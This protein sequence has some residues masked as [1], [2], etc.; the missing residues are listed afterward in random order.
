ME[1]KVE[2]GEYRL[3]KN[4]FLTDEDLS[5]SGWYGLTYFELHQHRPGSDFTSS[6]NMNEESFNRLY[7]M[8]T[9]M[10]KQMEW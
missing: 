10:K 6:I 7:D 4:C 5:L 8:M 9:E 1:I 2:N 3:H